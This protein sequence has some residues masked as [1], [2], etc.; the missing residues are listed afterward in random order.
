MNKMNIVRMILK[1]AGGRI[2]NAAGAIDS[3]DNMFAG[4]SGNAVSDKVGKMLGA[5]GNANPIADPNSQEDNQGG[6]AQT[7]TTIS[8][9]TEQPE[10]ETDTSV[11]TD[12]E[13]FSDGRLKDTYAEY[14]AKNPQQ[15]GNKGMLKN[16]DLDP[17]SSKPVTES[18]SSGGGSIGAM[19]NMFKDIMGSSGG[20]GVSDMGGD[21][22]DMASDMG[23]M[24][25]D[26]GDA[27]SDERLK[28]IFGENQDAIRAFAKINAIKFTYN[29]KA[30]EIPG[31]EERGVD[32]DVHYGVKAQ[33]IAENPFTESAVKKDPLS[34]YLTIDIKE[35]T[36]ANTAIIS[37][38]CKRILIIEKVLGIKVV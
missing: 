11:D 17:M 26:V 38:I 33:E 31:S 20:E 12:T 18:N 35:L 19:A 7:D 28:H 16:L 5:S 10:V 22:A 30:K 2:E 23:D 27:A 36:M 25:S 37:E 9:E 1:E 4:S 14:K 15:K 21:S 13:T 32:D 8:T 6:Q 3:K 34:E 29:D 24:A